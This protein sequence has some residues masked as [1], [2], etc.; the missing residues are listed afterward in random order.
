MLTKGDDYPLHQTPEP[1]AWSGSD[2][3]FYDRYF[4]NGYS[5]DGSLFFAAAMGLYPQLDIIDASFCLLVDGVQHNVRASRHLGSERLDLNVGPIRIEIVAPLQSLRI[6]VA[7]AD[8]PIT[9]DL[10]FTARHAPI[11]EPRFIRRNGPRMFM[12]YTRMT[13]NG[14]WSGT[15][16]INGTE[17]TL[18]PKRH[19]GT[20][21]RSWGIRPIGAPDSQPPPSGNLPQFYWLWTPLNF[22]DHMSFFHSN[23]DGDGLPWNRRAVVAT[24]DGSDPHEYDDV[25]YDVRYRPGT[26]RVERMQAFLCNDRDIEIIVEPAG[27]VF[28]M[29]GLGYTHPK[30]GHGIDHGGAE[31][32]YD[33]IETESADPLDP[34]HIHVQAFTSATLRLDGKDQQGHGV[35]EQLLIGP[36]ATSGLKGLLDP[37]S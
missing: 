14:G 3:N 21:D 28:H 37:H 9:A 11:E 36:H 23:D 32:G 19:L 34:L 33:T 35:L 31:F 1:V 17:H 10:T 8:A 27:P 26:R 2:R 22:D 20:R 24:T 5:S 29:S 7:D 6:I 16:S 13:Q 4:F 30:W 25:V 15:I 12:D 18:S